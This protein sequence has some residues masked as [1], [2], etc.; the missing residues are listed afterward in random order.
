MV[1]TNKDYF[2]KPRTANYF[3]NLLLNDPGKLFRKYAI[4]PADSSS[5]YMVP[6]SDTDV[7]TMRR[8]LNIGA[9]E[10]G[11]VPANRIIGY[12]HIEKKSRTAALTSR[13]EGA[14]CLFLEVQNTPD[15]NK[16]PIYYLPWCPGKV[17]DLTIP[18]KNALVAS[19]D[20]FFTAAI[21]GCSV[22]IQGTPANPTIYHA[23]GNPVQAGRDTAKVWRQLDA[24]LDGNI[25]EAW[26]AWIRAHQ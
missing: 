1:P 5:D 20:I 18:A 6:T 9:V 26:K 2:N 25:F 14:D 7:Q 3:D 4:H 16:V 11:A 17:L 8:A 10:S 21:N 12:C 23:G 19:P 13:M 22:F 24:A 15:P